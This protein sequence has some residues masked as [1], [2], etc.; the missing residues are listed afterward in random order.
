[1][2]MAWDLQGF[3]I[4]VYGTAIGLSASE[5]GWILGV[6]ASATF[7]VRLLMPLIARHL[8][9]WQTITAAFAFGALAYALFPIFENFYTLAAIAFLLGLALGS[10]QPNVMTLIHTETPAGRTGEALGLRTMLLNICHTTLPVIFGAAG[11]VI[12]AGAVFY[13]VA[14]IMGGVSVF[15]SKCEKHSAS[16]ASR[17]VVEELGKEREN[18][19]DSKP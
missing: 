7:F 14:G 16:R 2:S 3:M 6:F 10:S 4:P 5:V 18:A 9:E 19:T 11:N 12:G 17:R 8:T 15:T 13:I 1:M